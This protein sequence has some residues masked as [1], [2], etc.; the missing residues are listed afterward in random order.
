MVKE[1]KTHAPA[2]AFFQEIKRQHPDTIVLMRLGDFYDTFDGDAQTCVDELDWI[3]TPVSIGGE[4]VKFAGVP[5][6]RVD[7]YVAQLVEKGYRV[8]LCD[9]VKGENDELI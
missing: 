1:N 4:L 2:Y 8:T 7:Y 3:M 6:F 9:L 5:H